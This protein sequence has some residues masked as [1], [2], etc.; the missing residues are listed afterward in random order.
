MTHEIDEREW[1][2]QESGRRRE[3]D[4][5]ESYRR[6]AQV[7]SEPPRG[8]LPRDFAARMAARAIEAEA[9]GFERLLI[10]LLVVALGVS[11]AWYLPPFG[12]GW[13]PALAGCLGASWLFERWQT[14]AR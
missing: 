13:L 3:A 10:G 7:L 5:A 6:M 1:Q 11:V 12:S 8:A 4:A 9:D 14:R 2:A